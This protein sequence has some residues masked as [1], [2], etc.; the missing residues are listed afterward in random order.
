MS[1]WLTGWLSSWASSWGSSGQITLPNVP[2]T[3]KIMESIPK[4]NIITVRYE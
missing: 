3:A 2:L 4:E 1:S